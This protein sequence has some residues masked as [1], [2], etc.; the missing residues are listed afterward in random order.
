MKILSK[1]EFFKVLTKINNKAKSRQNEYLLWKKQDAKENRA[2]EKAQD[3]IIKMAALK[4]S[5]L[6][7]NVW[8]KTLDAI[9]IR[10]QSQKILINNLK[11]WTTAY[12]STHSFKRL[13]YVFG[14]SGTGKSYIAKIF[15]SHL[16]SKK[17]YDVSF[18]S[19]S[20]FII[21]YRDFSKKMD[22]DKVI[23][24]HILILDDFCSHNS[25]KLVVELLHAVL[26]QRISAQKPTLITSNV[27]MNNVASFL[28]KTGR[29]SFVSNKMCEAIE[30]RV[31]EL[32][33]PVA[34][35]GTSL[36]IEDAWARHK[37]NP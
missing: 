23:K 24:P 4:N 3:R 22:I 31:F 30:D 27:E 9:Q 21:N 10:N 28:Y 32:C 33:P 20:N 1:P 37:K 8:D 11:L 12:T 5:G 14:S 34:L 17:I 36:R 26:D 15:I 6:P 29:N 16:I 2:E 7:R 19:L 18:C 13:P 25:T 35:K